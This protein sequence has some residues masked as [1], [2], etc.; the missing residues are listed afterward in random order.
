MI[1]IKRAMG[2]EVSPFLPV[3]CDVHALAH[4]LQV[5]RYAGPEICRGEGR[6]LTVAVLFFIIS[7]LLTLCDV[8]SAAVVPLLLSPVSFV[9]FF[10]FF[11]PSLPLVLMTR[12]LSAHHRVLP[13]KQQS[14]EP[15]GFGGRLRVRELMRSSDVWMGAT[16]KLLG[17]ASVR[18]A[19]SKIGTIK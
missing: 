4:I 14:S 1:N 6:R 13:N 17:G 2:A 19:R 3:R 11:S 16:D 9:Y 18:Q 7:V 15:K 5:L 8:L 12:P 10:F